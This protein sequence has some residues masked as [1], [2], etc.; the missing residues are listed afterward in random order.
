MEHSRHSGRAGSV[1]TPFYSR[2]S[3]YLAR[4]IET[5]ARLIAPGRSARSGS[6]RARHVCRLTARTSAK[7][8]Y[9]A[10]TAGVPR[11]YLATWIPA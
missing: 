2:I 4:T 1:R 10:L 3:G 9:T 11:T 8:I 6:W 7:V 5:R